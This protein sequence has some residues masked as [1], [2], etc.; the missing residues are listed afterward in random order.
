MEKLIQKVAFGLVGSKALKS[1]KYLFPLKDDTL[2]MWS[3]VLGTM[4]AN[5]EKMFTKGHGT[6]FSLSDDKKIIKHE[7]VGLSNGLGWSLDGK[8]MY[9]VDTL[10]RTL[11]AFDYD[12]DKGVICKL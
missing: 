5:P 7:T 10:E 12:L 6:L 4:I 9:Y 1:Y 2:P 8:T 11:D 3:F